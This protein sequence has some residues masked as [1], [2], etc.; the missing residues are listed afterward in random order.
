M[1]LSFENII[2]KYKS[3]THKQQLLIALA[4]FIFGVVIL[5]NAIVYGIAAIVSFKLVNKKLWKNIGV[6]FFT[7]ATV[8]SLLLFVPDDSTLT[9][10]TET[11]QVEQN[12]I[13]TNENL[14]VEEQISNHTSTSI[15]TPDSLSKA[16]EVVKVV[17]G[18]TIDVSIN[19]KTE[20]IRLIGIN[21]PETVD[22]RKPV[23]CFGVEA[24]NKAKE[25]LS[26]KK[27]TLESDSSQGERDQYDRLLR[28][29][30]LEDAT[31]I[32]L[33]MIQSGYAYEYT[34]NLPYKYQKEFKEAQQQASVSK[35]GLW[36]DTCQT[37]VTQTQPPSATP[38]PFSAPI[39]NSN[40][41]TIK[42]NIS[43]SDE[44]IFHTISCGSYSKTVID[45]SKGEKWF[46]SEQEAL[47]AGW[48]RALNC[49]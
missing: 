10:V 13:L 8:F 33:Q 49:N 42:G 40:S 17:D 23:E 31:N 28:Y 7:L 38:V 30:F 9:K 22:P 35:I 2:A 18:D 39:S 14:K 44:K 47:D 12:P 15:S 29:V 41:C 20:R 36:G 21:T 45:E 34:Y 5:P 26:G 3:F 1:K 27:V 48:R 19:G 43:S 46:C 16:Y 11:V 24:S 25:L 6:S 32:N 4:I 37:P